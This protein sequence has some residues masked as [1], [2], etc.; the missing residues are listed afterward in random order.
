MGR[1]LRGREEEI[2]G[3]EHFFPCEALVRRL[4]QG[5]E[6]NSRGGALFSL[7]G[8]CEEATSRGKG[9]FQERGAFFPVRPL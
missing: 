2:P 3:I 6:G 8:P 7:W 5:G 4:L 1:V 9:K